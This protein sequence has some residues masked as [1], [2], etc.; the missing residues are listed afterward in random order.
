MKLK[1][2]LKQEV[3]VDN[4]TKLLAIDI[5]LRGTKIWKH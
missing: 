3:D 5:I 1:K 2:K 4:E